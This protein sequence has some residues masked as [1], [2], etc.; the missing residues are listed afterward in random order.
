MILMYTII[1]KIVAFCTGHT[2]GI[3]RGVLGNAHYYLNQQEGVDEIISREEEVKKCKEPF[4]RFSDRIMN[5]ALH[6]EMLN[7]EDF[8]IDGSDFIITDY[9]PLG[10]IKMPVAV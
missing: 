8:A 1:N 9:E 6:G 2:P 7:L 10:A 4:I 5:K 3:V